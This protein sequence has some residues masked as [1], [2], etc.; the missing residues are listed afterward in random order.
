MPNSFCK[1]GLQVASLVVS[2][3]LLL[4]AP[5]WAQ[6]ENHQ[7]IKAMPAKPT[8]S[9]NKANTSTCAGGPNV[10]GSWS[11]PTSLNGVVAIHSVLL[12][13][14]KV[15][16]W[17][18]PLGTATNAPYAIFDPVAKTV[19]NSTIPIQGDFFCSGQNVMPDG[20]VLIVGGLLGNPF[21][22][23]P[24][25]G[26]T[27]KVIFDPVP[28]TWSTGSTGSQMINARWYPTAVERPDGQVMIVTGKN[29]NGNA[30]QLPSEV[31]NPATDT[32]TQLPASANVL[33]TDDTYL[34]MKVIPSGNI[35]MAGATSPTR[36]FNVSRNIWTQM[37]TMTF[38]NR[39]H[40]A[41]VI[42]PGT[43]TKP[44]SSI[45]TVGGTNSFTGGGATA[46]SEMIDLTQP[47]PAWVS[48]GSLSIPRYNANLVILADGNLLTV[49][50][51]QQQKYT[52]PVMTP[53]LYNVAADTWT[54]MADQSAPR[55]YHSSALLLPDGTVYSAGSD[56]PAN[57]AT[58]VTYEIFSPPY[59]FD[60]S[61]NAAVRPT[62]TGVPPQIAYNVKF[63]ITTPDAANIKS[64]ALVK[65]AATTHDNDMDE[66]YI[67]LKF[68][69]GTGQLTA[70][71][72]LNTNYAPP[73]YYMVVIVNTS[74][75]P[76]VMPFT[77]LCPSTGCI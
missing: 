52:A 66:R 74:G 38:G 34:K 59:L 62:I 77:Q 29:Q 71:S 60:S 45:F 25:K 14:G 41:A 50:G 64:V 49:G 72:P 58:D 36:L 27:G 69:V 57:T 33:A 75:V 55:S 7:G 47:T 10:C 1:R 67:P 31:Y 9:I 20:R 42:L 23:A 11:A 68:N 30:I 17:W 18:Y 51:A 61:G 8:S 13:S 24:D 12:H 28:Q 73:G 26:T 46:T 21:P 53:E 48:K 65:P 54:E 6:H 35:F 15:L 76:S 5:V 4:A 16:S 56:D 44:L 39:F 19:L 32:F 43:S 63:L 22:H 40:G 3:T 37:G 2:L 70:N